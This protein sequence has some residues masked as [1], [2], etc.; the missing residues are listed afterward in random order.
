MMQS[1]DELLTAWILRGL[2]VQKLVH[3]SLASKP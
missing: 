3:L 2:A 1:A